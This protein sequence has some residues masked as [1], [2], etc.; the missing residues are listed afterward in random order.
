MLTRVAA[1]L[2]LCLGLAAC[3][4][5][6]VPVATTLFQGLGDVKVL[7][8]RLVPSG[9]SS[10]ATGAGSLGYVIARLE[11]TNDLGID[12]TPRVSNF[13]LEDRSGT[14][15]QAHDSGSSVFTGISNSQELLKKDEKRVYTVGFRT[16]DPNVSGT[17][18]YD[19][20]NQ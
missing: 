17:I 7:D 5:N 10:P 16:S 13:V 1:A 20:T 19:K 3:N 4:Q 6:D 15:Y 14:R 18:Y 8:A 12:T 2:A 9:D 11:F